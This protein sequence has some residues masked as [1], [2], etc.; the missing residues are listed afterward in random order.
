[1]DES[2]NNLRTI[3]IK[4]RLRP[5]R[6]VYLIGENYSLEYFYKLMISTVTIWGYLR[7]FIYIPVSEDYIEPVFAKIIK[8]FDP[9]MIESKIHISQNLQKHICSIC[10]P[11]KYFEVNSDVDPT[12]IHE[13]SY[14]FSKNF[15]ILRQE[16]SRILNI[17]PNSDDILTKLLFFDK[18]GFASERFTSLLQQNDIKFLESELNEKNDS[19]YKNKLS[20][21]IIGNI[22][23]FKDQEQD[24]FVSDVG[25][26][27][28]GRYNFKGDI[29]Q[30]K[31]PYI[32]VIGDSIKDYCFYYALSR[33][34]IKVLWFPYSYVNKFTSDNSKELSLITYFTS[35][36]IHDLEFR[37]GK[38]NL[39]LTSNSLNYDDLESFK[40]I[41]VS[42]TIVNSK[43]LKERIYI[44][45]D[46]ESFVIKTLY[47]I[48]INN[49]YDQ[50]LLLLNGR[51]VEK[52]KTLK[53][54]NFS[55]D[56]QEVRWL[57]EVYLKNLELPNKTCFNQFF[58]WPNPKAVLSQGDYRIS[59][60]GFVYLSNNHLFM[61]GLTQDLLLMKPYFYLPSDFEIFRAFFKSVGYD[62][63]VSDKGSYQLKTNELFADKDEFFR[64]FT[65][66]N[67]I[68]LLNLF[69]NGGL[70]AGV[71]E[72]RRF[73]KFSDIKSIYGQKTNSVLDFLIDRNVLQR[74]LILKCKHCRNAC[75]Y[76]L[77]E[78]TSIFKCK[79]CSTRQVIKSFNNFGKD[80][81]EWYYS[82]N[83]I[84]YQGH[85]NDMLVPILTLNHLR[86][87]AKNTFIYVPEL[88][89]RKNQDYV[90][91]D[92]EIDIC[93]ISDS[94]MIIG[95][96]K[97]NNK[98][99][100]KEINKI[101]NLALKSYLDTVV[102]STT[103]DDFAKD[104]L[105]RIEPIKNDL[106]KIFAKVII[107]TKNHLYS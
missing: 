6:K 2:K 75:Y 63:K 104:T 103:K 33:L 41:L 20:K 22:K 55:P 77:E 34:R 1:M 102:F 79:R 67:N 17:Y 39:I 61:P 15:S 40:S 35:N 52:I 95:E 31:D 91:P 14:P 21:I 93:C 50:D 83:E 9:D 90:K 101:R 8:E 4:K 76:K 45:K 100:Q 92:M 94:E 60:N 82:L 36:L 7:N 80:E 37:E 44:N 106:K 54:L 96:C 13:P 25:E 30:W 56:P 81:P 29:E 57:T 49:I 74:G 11:L 84:V 59:K 46:L 98:I 68:T 71:D 105:D 87:N 19:S 107:L 66:K 88:E 26:I 97:S 58:S 73:I 10:N 5:P 38:I 18:F 42:N 65:E 12:V 89:L 32:L 48:E 24:K 53:P 47:D 86:Q 16:N 43:K 64:F 69:K 99:T 23:E 72:K 85:I 27:F 3:E 70:D 51:S 78:L 28:L 62:I